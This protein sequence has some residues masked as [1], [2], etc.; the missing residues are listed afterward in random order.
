MSEC[1]LPIHPRTGMRAVGIVAGRPVWPILGGEESADAA[2]QA[3]ATKAASDATAASAYVAP[4]SQADLDKIIE[5]R[6][7]RERAKFSDYE[8]LKTKAARADALE[9][10]L[11]SESDKAAKAA[12]D[13]ERA[14]ANDEWT[15]RVVKAEF[16]AAAK[17]VLTDDQLAALIEDLDLKK[18]V[19]DKGDADEEKIAKKVAAFA[20]ASSTATKTPPR[21]LGQGAQPPSNVKPGDQGRAMAEKRFGKNK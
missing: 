2:A 1:T 3:A 18:Y 9:A 12:R 20:P 17:G 21:Q 7:A 4:S 19:T 6:L 16:K 15:P 5:S 11:G 13:E 8:D 14:K 10:E